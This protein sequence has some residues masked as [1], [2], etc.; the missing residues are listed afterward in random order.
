MKR[1]RLTSTRVTLPAATSPRSLLTDTLKVRRRPSTRSSIASARTVTPTGAGMRWSSC[2]RMPTLVTWGSSRPAMAATLASSTRATTRGVPSM[3]TSP[4]R[5]EA[6]VSL[7]PTVSSI[8]ALSPGCTVT[9]LPYE[10]P[11]KQ[12]NTS[13]SGSIHVI[14]DN[15]VQRVLAVAL[16][17]GGDLA[18]VFAEDKRLSSGH[19]DDGRVEELTSGLDRGAGIRVVRGDTTGFAHTADLS[20]PGLKGAA[21][22]AAAAARAGGGGVHEVALQPRADRQAHPIAEYPA[23]VPKA[24]KVE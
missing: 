18:E 14:E 7:S 13:R 9:A 20:E 11:P 21:E 12:A 17:T 22:A 2:T 5:N 6:A 3:G 10:L 16:R 8:V 15:V 23:D 19:L 4:E 24:R 1:S